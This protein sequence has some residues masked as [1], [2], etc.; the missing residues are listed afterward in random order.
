[1]QNYVFIL[2]TNKQ[3]LNPVPPARARELLA[4][5]KT[6][7]HIVFSLTATKVASRF[8]LRNRIFALLALEVF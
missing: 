2:D 5:G 6:V 7:M 3:P 8:P 4:K 1:M